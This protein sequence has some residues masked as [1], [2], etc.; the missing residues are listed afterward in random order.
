MILSQEE[1]LYY[2]M[3]ESFQYFGCECDLMFYLSVYTSDHFLPMVQC[4]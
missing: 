3:F 2:N 4:S 1:V